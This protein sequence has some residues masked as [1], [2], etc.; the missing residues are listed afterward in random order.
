MENY[1]LVGEARGIGFL[2][3][4]ELV[5]IKRLR[6]RYDPSASAGTLCREAALDNELIMQSVGDTVIISL[7]LIINIEQID[8]LI[9][10]VGKSLDDA[11]RKLMNPK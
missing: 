4:L 8:G 2:G 11:F 7:P 1:P 3:A 9:E 5:Q 6:K 10:L